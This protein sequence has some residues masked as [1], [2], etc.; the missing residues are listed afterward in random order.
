MGWGTSLHARQKLLV[1]VLK[2]G[3]CTLVVQC[4]V[5]M[6]NSLICVCFLNIDDAENK[7]PYRNWQKLSN[8]F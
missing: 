3:I 5:L 6:K 4:I 1:H 7:T 8:F 2:K